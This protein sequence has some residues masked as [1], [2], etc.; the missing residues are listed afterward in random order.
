MATRI[1]T[2]TCSPFQENTYVVFD[3]SKQAVL[4]DPGCYEAFERT[5]LADFISNNKLELVRCL[6]THAHLDHVFGCAWVQ[7]TYGLLPEC[8]EDEL[9]VLARAQQTALGYGIPMEQPPQPAAFIEPGKDISFGHTSFEV[10]F[11]PGHSPA[12][13]VFYCAQS[14]FV[15]AGD[16]LFNGSIGRTDLPGGHHDTLIVKIKTELFSLPEDTK[17]YSGHGLTTTIGR[18]KR[19]NPFFQ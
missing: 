8:H 1:Q 5:Q 18:E 17:V 12:S 19:N 3:E 6:L 2:F 9:G 14:G 10:R 13:V 15:I 11:V 7:R 16:T 4:I